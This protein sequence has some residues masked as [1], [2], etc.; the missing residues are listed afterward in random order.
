MAFASLFLF[1]DVL[2]LL[3]S[4]R[5]RLHVEKALIVREI[6]EII[7]HFRQQAWKFAPRGIFGRWIQKLTDT[8]VLTKGL[9]AI[10]NYNMAAMAKLGKNE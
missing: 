1:A 7:V 4:D 6:G 5:D 3:V 10:L 2:A 9:A 8:R